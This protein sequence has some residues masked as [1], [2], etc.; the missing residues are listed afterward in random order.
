VPALTKV[1]H[2]LAPWNER[3]YSSIPVQSAREKV[4]ASCIALDQI[5]VRQRDN[6]M[7]K[8]NPVQGSE[9]FYAENECVKGKTVRA[10][11]LALLLFMTAAA[12]AQTAPTVNTPRP[13]DALGMSYANLKP[14][15][16]PCDKECGKHAKAAEL[17]HRAT[18]DVPPYTYTV[19]SGKVVEV[20][21]TTDSFQGFLDEGK[22]AWGPPTSLDYQ[23]LVSPFGTE[24]RVGTARWELPGGVIV[25][26]RE[27][28]MP[29][30]LLGVAKVKTTDH[31]TVHITQKEAPTDGVIVII[32]NPS[33]QQAENPKPR[34]VLGEPRRESVNSTDEKAKQQ[35]Q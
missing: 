33:A 8:P 5:R 13:L 11:T 3:L 1:K 23:N 29:G 35:S 12:N 15:L 31:K 4:E 28:K 16:V 32:S 25:D 20:M 27:T 17:G 9:T 6:K 34:S 30:K 10:V 22:E 24:S 18:F 7:A 19:E 14:Y 26:A 21:I 2:G